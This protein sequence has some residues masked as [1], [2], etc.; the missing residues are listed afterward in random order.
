MVEISLYGFG[1]GLGRATGRGYSTAGARAARSGA[2]IS[3]LL[4]AFRCGSAALVQRAKPAGPL[5]PACSRREHPGVSR[6]VRPAVL[7]NMSSG[8]F[9]QRRSL[10]GRPAREGRSIAPALP[11]LSLAPARLSLSVL[12]VP[13]GAKTTL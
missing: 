13:A 3:R 1:E 10:C 12:L 7:T 4:P 2:G 11:G 8:R 5:G 6:G 9:S